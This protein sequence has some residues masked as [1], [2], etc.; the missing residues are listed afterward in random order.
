[1][2]HGASAHSRA[3]PL[4]KAWWP[5]MNDWSVPFVGSVL[6]PT[7]F[8]PASEAAFVHALALALARQTRLTIL[9]ASKDKDDQWMRFPQVRKTL[10]RW[11]LLEEGSGRS[12]V[13]D[14]LGVYVR[15]IGVDA[16]SPFKAT[17]DFLERD[18][19]DLVVLATEGRDGVPGFLRPSVAERVLRHSGS[20]TLFVPE[21]ARGFVSRDDGTITLNKIL[22]PVD[23][24]PDSSEVLIR[25]ARAAGLLDEP[26]IEIV[27]LHVGEGDFPEIDLPS[28]D[29]YRWR[30]EQGQG[31]V[32]EEILR[33][34]EEEEVDLV[35][36]ATDGRDGLLDVFR[37]SWTERVVRRIACPLLAVP[38]V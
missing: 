29:G 12:A 31:D 34:A 35:A 1:M 25:V 32:L 27:V 22:V 7:D 13:G 11:G 38:A 36:M 4:P 20:M 17:M 9:N 15:K 28:G 30:K 24:Q 26:S 18:P 19:T 10:E 5:S 37:G 14:E 6:H 23:F 2:V 16:G 8:S 3:P 21:K 33:T